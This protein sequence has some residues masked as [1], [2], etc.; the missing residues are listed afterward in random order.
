MIA[1]IFATSFV[2]LVLLLKIY[3]S[4]KDKHNESSSRPDKEMS[5]WLEKKMRAL[6]K[7]NLEEFES[8]LRN[9]ECPNCG[10]EMGLKTYGSA[11]QFSDHWCNKCGFIT[12]ME[13]LC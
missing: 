12:L 8:K 4:I 3:L 13:V 10:S 7:E 2:S 6:R 5:P 11:D 1:V 9:N